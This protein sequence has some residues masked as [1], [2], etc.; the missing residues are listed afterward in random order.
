MA[1]F[2]DYLHDV[3][4]LVPTTIF[5]KVRVIRRLR[6]RVNLWDVSAAR[7]GWIII[8]S[9]MVLSGRIG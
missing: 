6:K 2:G 7:V 8:R 9:I 5:D 1:N 4:R 3:R